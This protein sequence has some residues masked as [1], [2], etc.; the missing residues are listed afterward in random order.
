MVEWQFWIILG[1]IFIVLEIITP[2]FFFFWF[3][4]SSFI[5]AIFG[6]FISNKIINSV[7]FIIFSTIL[8]LFSRKI[9]KKWIN[10]L[11]NK[12][13][14]LDELIGKTGLALSD[15]DKNNSGIVKVFSEQW[16]AYSEEGEVK[17]GDKVI[18]LKRE[19]NMLIV[20]KIL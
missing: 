10:P 1:I 7:I 19:S 3:G 13:F 8:W 5:T 14:H 6:L 4:L 18:V 17:K 15:F 11:Q 16:S 12:N 2:T 20:K 9:V